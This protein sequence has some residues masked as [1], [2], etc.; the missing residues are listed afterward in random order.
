MEYD[1]IV[2]GSGASGLSFAALMEQRGYLVAVLEA[3]SLPGG[4]S[5]YFE[6][7][8]FTF[9]AGATTLSGLLPG[10]PLSELIRRLNLK[11]E[12][13]PIDPG[14]VSIFKNKKLRRYRDQ[15]AWLAELEKTFPGQNHTELW[16][17][18]SDVEKKGWNLSTSFKNIPI[19]SVR[20]LGEFFTLK[21]F[22]A[23]LSVPHLFKSVADE[24]KKYSI[25]D[26]DYLRVIDEMLFI[27]AQNQRSDTP[28]LMGAM[29]L[30]YP[31]DTAY[32]MG[33]MKA[34]SEALA[35]KCSHIFYRHQVT[36]I[37]P[38][39]EGHEGFIVETTKGNFKTKNLIST[40][41]IWNHEVLFDNSSAKKFFAPKNI[42]QKNDCWSAFMLYFTIPLDKKRE[43]LYF[44]MHCDSIPNCDTHSF[45]VSMSIGRIRAIIP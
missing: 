41:P 7:D 35:K 43:G 21:T 4:C 44:Q 2:I 23:L 32:A 38:Q 1:Y 10:R 12:L 45:F 16:N 19:R 36:K 13:M 9:D 39:N 6:R 42:T 29:G 15:K 14:I 27:T 24:F 33:G 28:L 8:G 17:H 3:H 31:S 22:S 5:S 25:T 18:L 34:F 11:M 26:E 30:C 40:I 20:S 37:I